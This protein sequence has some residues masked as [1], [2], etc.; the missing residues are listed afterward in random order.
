M[1]EFIVV[2]EGDFEERYRPI[3]DEDGSWREFWPGDPRAVEILAAAL[4]ERRIWT[5]LDVDGFTM[6]SSGQHFVNRL[7][8]Y[9][10]ESAVAEN[11]DVGV[12]DEEELA[13]WESLR[14]REV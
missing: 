3:L 7:G 5:M 12:Y 13:E 2:D 14:L 1:A 6:L 9:V 8:Y 11:L 10:T 4:A